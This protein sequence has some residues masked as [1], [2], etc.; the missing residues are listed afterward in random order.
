MTSWSTPTQLTECEAA[1]AE[2]EREL[3]AHSKQWEE[4][5][6][7]AQRDA[8]TISLL[9]ACKRELEGELLDRQGNI[10]HLEGLLQEVIYQA[11]RRK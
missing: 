4:H 2:V 6:E 5:Q 3:R 8:N 7:V 10:R 11:L 9:T 1:V